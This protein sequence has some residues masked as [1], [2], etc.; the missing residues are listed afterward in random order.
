MASLAPCAPYHLDARTPLLRPP[1]RCS[2][3]KAL[4]HCSKRTVQD[5]GLQ[6]PSLVWGVAI[7]NGCRTSAPEPPPRR[8]SIAGLPPACQ[9]LR[10][11]AC[12]F[13]P[14]CPYALMPLCPYVSM[15]YA[16]HPPAISPFPI[17]TRSRYPLSMTTTRIHTASPGVYPERSRRV[18]P[19]HPVPDPDWG[20]GIQERRGAS[21]GSQNAHLSTLNFAP[22]FDS[23]LTSAKICFAFSLV[24]DITLETNTLLR[25]DATPPLT[26]ISRLTPPFTTPQNRVMSSKSISPSVLPCI[27]PP[28]KPARTT[29]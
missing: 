9:S 22:E 16:P 5:K 2:L 18:L 24:L 19:A 10:L 7:P 20:A 1:E 26:A 27:I 8:R 12:P 17:P 3:A 29:S 14:P 6:C 28:T 11:L 4:P 21:L 15:S 13:G 23:F 25:H